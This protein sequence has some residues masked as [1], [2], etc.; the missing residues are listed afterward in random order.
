ML[1]PYQGQG[2]RVKAQT[3]PLSAFSFELSAIQW[4]LQSSP[5]SSIPFADFFLDGIA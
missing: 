1:L 4:T 2:S 5:I 3:G